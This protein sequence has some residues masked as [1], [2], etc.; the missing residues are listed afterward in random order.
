[1]ESAKNKEKNSLVEI[2]KN[3]KNLVEFLSNLK[4]PFEYAD[5]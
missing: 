3:Q 5:G 1:M 2:L 4:G